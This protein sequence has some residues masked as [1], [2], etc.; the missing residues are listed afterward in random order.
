MVLYLADRIG[1]Q[2]LF[3]LALVDAE[4]FATAYERAIDT[5]LTAFIP[6]WSQWIFS[7]SAESLYGITPY[8]PP[9]ALPSPTET[10]SATPTPTSTPT[11][12]FT[13]SLTASLT[14]R[15]VRTYTPPLTVTPSQTPPPPP[16]TVTPRPPGSLQ[17][18]TPTPTALQVTLAQPSVQAGAITFLLLLLG[19]LVFLFIRLGNRR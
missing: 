9:T 4:D 11:P 3:D 14:P 17:A 5:P 13:P 19:L 8:Q 15:G 7:R 1:V 6:A 12:T 16:P 10:P 2:G 18:L